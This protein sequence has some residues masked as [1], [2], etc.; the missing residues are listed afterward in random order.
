MSLTKEASSVRG[1]VPSRF[2]VSVDS[3]KVKVL[4]FDTDLEV[5]ILKGFSGGLILGEA[6]ASVVSVEDGCLDVCDSGAMI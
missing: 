2:F 1:G 3:K 5:L 6:H 4:C